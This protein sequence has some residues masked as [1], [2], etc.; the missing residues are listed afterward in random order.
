M[1][2]QKR[3]KSK[4]Y[5]YR[6]RVLAVKSEQR[7]R[8]EGNEAMA[9]SG[10]PPVNTPD[11]AAPMT[12]DP[13]PTEASKPEAQAP[14]SAAEPPVA[15]ADPAVLTPPE[16]PLASSTGDAGELKPP[17][18]LPSADVKTVE[19][20]SASSTGEGTSAAA[21]SERAGKKP[22]AEPSTL[23]QFIEYAYGRK[24]QP[25]TLKSKV[26]KQIAQ[27]ARLDD[28]ALSRLLQ[29]AKGD[30][31]LAVPRQILLL[32][33]EVTGFLNLK[34]AMTSFVS[35]VMLRHP[36]FS[37][38]GVQGALRNLP[39]GLP[40]AEALARVASFGPP[41]SAE[42]EP[43]KG[44]D[45]RDLRQNAVR[46]FVTWLAVNRSL[47][48]E[49]L[50][51][52]LFQVVWQPA[53]KDLADDNARLRALT[54]IGQAA[55]VGLAC[56]RFRQQAIEARAQREQTQR[57][58]ISLRDRLSAAETQLSDTA[59]QLEAVRAELQALRESSSAEMDAL[60]GQHADERT[61][62]QHQMEQLRG[63]LVK[64]LTD[65]VE[66]LEVGLSALRKETPRVPVMVE[67]A[68]HVV[69]ELRAEVQ[70][71]REE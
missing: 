46:L 19:S 12:P 3:K 66:M 56:Q 50:S 39:E 16:V 45:L 53:A 65:S 44:S 21:K 52:L 33:K 61:H 47:N 63:R 13:V 26:E 15:T 37:D 58:A 17:A 7:Q 1:K 42:A 22:K 43:L 40:P 54:D 70:E 68:D 23:E 18:E 60:R 32:S 35:N 2:E 41:P 62:L 55:G 9:T 27:N 71:L 10:T 59:E 49:E 6:A 64:R 36:V 57:E 31:L 20:T 51:S 5:D 30:T 4:R 67:R 11:A 25:L 8:Q 34:A 14:M 69:D 48:F 24:G 28:A 38:T 29:L